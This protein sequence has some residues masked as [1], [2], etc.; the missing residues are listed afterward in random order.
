M[1]KVQKYRYNGDKK[2][3]FDLSHI[4]YNPYN[5]DENPGKASKHLRKIVIECLSKIDQNK[6]LFVKHAAES[7]DFDCLAVLF[8]AHKS[9]SKS[10]D[11]SIE[12][13]EIMAISRLLEL[14][15]LTAQLLVMKTTP[16]NEYK[17]KLSPF[18]EAV[19]EY[20][21]KYFSRY[22]IPKK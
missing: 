4:R 15:L 1:L 13:H 7:L 21:I 19:F 22:Y 10:V 18:G 16:G 2:I 3:P 12:I 6:S 20:N 14:C 11:H 9:P 8:N 17:Y 5:P